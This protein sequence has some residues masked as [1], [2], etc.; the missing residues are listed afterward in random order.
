MPETP[1]T[2]AFMDLDAREA[3]TWHNSR[4]RQYWT[5]LAQAT[6]PF[7]STKTPA[8]RSSTSTC[9]TPPFPTRR[10]LAGPTTALSSPGSFFA[11][12]DASQPELSNDEML[13][14]LNTQFSQVNIFPFSSPFFGSMK[15][16]SR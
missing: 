8:T 9:A 1:E 4:T 2:L 13:G 14:I 3:A 5:G 7:S 12:S 11:A 16:P 6:G 15:N 10:F